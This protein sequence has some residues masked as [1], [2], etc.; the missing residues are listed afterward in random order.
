MATLTGQ[1]YGGGLQSIM[2]KE[3]DADSD[4]L[5]LLCLTASYTPDPDNHRYASSLTNELSTGG[6]YTSGGISLAGLSLSKVAANSWSQSRANST[7]YDV[8]I[9]VCS[10]AGTTASSAPTFPT[11]RFASVT[12]GGVTWVNLGRGAVVLTFTAPS[13][14]SFSAGPFRYMALVD[15]TP[16][17]AATNPILALLSFPTDVSGGG[18]PFNITPDGSG[19]LVL[20][21]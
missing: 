7:A 4:A 17:S 14:T 16:G 9:Y 19:V 20:P 18:G 11:T 13:V 5:K 6:G 12:D 2:N 3:V 10:V 15:T 1:V 21:Y 8:G